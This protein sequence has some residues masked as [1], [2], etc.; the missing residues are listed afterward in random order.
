MN[1]YAGIFRVKMELLLEYKK[2]HD[3]IWPEMRAAMNKCG[4]QNHSLFARP[5]GLVFI[6]AE[7]DNLQN[8]MSALAQTEVNSRWQKEM[9]KFF[10]SIDDSTNSAKTEMIPEIFHLD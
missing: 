4:I 10:V 9:S 6:Y 5:D 1:R 3:N 8:S 7:A 2:Y